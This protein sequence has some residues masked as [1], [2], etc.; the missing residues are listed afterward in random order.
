MDQMRRS[1]DLPTA[2]MDHEGIHASRLSRHLRAISERDLV[3]TNRHSSSP[4]VL[5]CPDREASPGREVAFEAGYFL[6]SRLTLAVGSN[7]RAI[8]PAITI[9]SSNL[10]LNGGKVLR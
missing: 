2:S 6:R 3:L 5:F 8:G 1:E 4:P 9:D 7:P 10:P